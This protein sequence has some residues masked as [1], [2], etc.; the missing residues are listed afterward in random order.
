MVGAGGEEAGRGDRFLWQGEL[1]GMYF[2]KKQQN[3]TLYKGNNIGNDVAKEFQE[4]NGHE[5]FYGS[6]PLSLKMMASPGIQQNRYLQNHT[7]VFSTNQIWKLDSLTEHY[8]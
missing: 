1:V 3:I 2:G 8:S 6:I 7:H 5:L 4:K